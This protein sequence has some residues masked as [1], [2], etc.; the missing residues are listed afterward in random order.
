[1]RF[2]FSYFSFFCVIL[3]LNGCGGGP[4]VRNGDPGGMV[5]DRP[6]FTLTAPR[7]GTWAYQ[8]VI[9]KK[10]YD[11]SF[12]QK[13]STTSSLVAAVVEANS[14]GSFATSAEI[15]EFVQVARKA[16]ID[17]VL[18]NLFVDEISP[19]SNFGN[20]CARYHTIAEDFTNR[21]KSG[22]PLFFEIVG[23]H[24]IHPANPEKMVLLSFTETGRRKKTS[25]SFMKHVDRFLGSFSLKTEYIEPDEE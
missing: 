6:G 23:Y 21:D 2:F 19:C 13:R 22:M 25:D 24:F 7:G 8:E 9:S 16:K 1:M 18:H 10:G 12:T 4:K 11:I 20:I 5:F 3:I 14:S 15:V 17:S